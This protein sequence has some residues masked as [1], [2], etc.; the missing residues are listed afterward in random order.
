MNSETRKSPHRS[1]VFLAVLLLPILMFGCSSSA[2][3]NDA[4]AVRDR[5]IAARFVAPFRDK[6]RGLSDK[7]LFQLSCRDMRV[8]CKKVITILEKKDPAFVKTLK[9]KTTKGGKPAAGSGSK[10]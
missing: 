9:G 2:T 4:L 10:Q 6:L 1:I 8:S 5:F 7:E 3:D